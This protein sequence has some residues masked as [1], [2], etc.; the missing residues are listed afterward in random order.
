MTT[1]TSAMPVQL[2]YEAHSVNNEGVVSKETVVIRP[3]QFA[4]LMWSRER[5]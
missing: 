1:M 4:W 3:G 5:T 2:S